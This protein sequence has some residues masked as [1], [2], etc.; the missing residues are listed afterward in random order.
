M[1]IQ[2]KDKETGFNNVKI[3]EKCM[4]IT[5]KYSDMQ[6][7]YVEIKFTAGVELNLSNV[8]SITIGEKS[9]D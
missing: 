8:A 5:E 9:N 2:Y 4:I 7:I 1:L 6:E 3:A